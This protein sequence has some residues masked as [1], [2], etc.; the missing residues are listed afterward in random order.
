MA[1]NTTATPDDTAD[2]DLAYEH[3]RELQWYWS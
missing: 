3:W 2:P 1:D